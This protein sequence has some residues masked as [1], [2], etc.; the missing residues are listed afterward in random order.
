MVFL[1]SSTTP[2]KFSTRSRALCRKIRKKFCVVGC[3]AFFFSLILLFR[4]QKIVCLRLCGLTPFFCVCNCQPEH[5]ELLSRS[6]SEF[7][8]C[9]LSEQLVESL[10][11][12]D[13]SGDT[14]LTKTQTPQRA[15]VS[16]KSKRRLPTVVSSFKKSLDEVRLSLPLRCRKKTPQN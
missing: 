9:E 1:A 5:V 13:G 16:T 7:V 10:S 15:V 4:F 8:G 3:Q 2:G 14:P 12:L 11:E 6:S